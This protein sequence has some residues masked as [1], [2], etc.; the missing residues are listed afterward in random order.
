VATCGTCSE[1]YRP[2][3]PAWPEGVCGECIA[4]RIEL[5][6]LR[7]VMGDQRKPMRRAVREQDI[8]ITVKEARR[9]A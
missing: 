2:M 8:E 3:T 4:A 9:Q 5:L 7:S 1:E 6:L